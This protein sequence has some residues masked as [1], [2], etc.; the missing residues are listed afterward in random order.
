MVFNTAILTA[1]FGES[2]D[3]FGSLSG[4]AGS[5]F[6]AT[7]SQELSYEFLCVAWCYTLTQILIL[8]F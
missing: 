3:L 2:F 5:A 7:G 8:R 4:F 1:F 6:L